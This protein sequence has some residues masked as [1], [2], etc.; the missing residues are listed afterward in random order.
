M[1]RSVCNL[2]GKLA[3]CN[4][5]ILLNSIRPIA[6]SV[7][8]FRDVVD[9]KEMLKAL[10]APDEG[11]IGENTAAL[12][13]VL[14]QKQNIFPTCDSQNRLFGGIPFK[15]LP[16]INI[17]VTK[18]NTIFNFTN[19]KGEPAIIRSC[20]IEGFKNARKGTN[21]AAQTT[22]ITFGKKTLERGVKMVRVR[23]RGLGPGR[24]ASIKGLQMAGVEVVSITDNTRVS[25]TPLRARKQ[26]RL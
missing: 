2:L 4:D 15:N 21:I 26:R 16:I 18:N 8:L 1:I 3:I 7:I 23:V 19:A 25:W 9:R 13:T 22:A 12:D 20:G 14:S 17:R 5:S 10:P 11:T 6:T 24:L